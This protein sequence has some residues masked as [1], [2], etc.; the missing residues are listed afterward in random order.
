MDDNNQAENILL[1]SM[2]H[3]A[4]WK[5]VSEYRAWARLYA[6]GNCTTGFFVHGLW[7]ETSVSDKPQDDFDPKL[8]PLD[9][10][11]SLALYYRDSPAPAGSR[12]N[13]AFWA[14]QWAKHGSRA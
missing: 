2:A 8:L 6:A 12:K 10:Q 1:L 7:P 9:L 5:D 4:T 3:P 14:T 11:E 13:I